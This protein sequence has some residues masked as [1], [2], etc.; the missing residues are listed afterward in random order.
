V[1]VCVLWCGHISLHH[2]TCQDG[3]NP[4]KHGNT[5]IWPIF[6]QVRNVHGVSYIDLSFGVLTFPSFP[7]HFPLLHFP[8]TFPFLPSY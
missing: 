1:C 6:F 2:P 7:L 8:F 4:F 3:F 5:S